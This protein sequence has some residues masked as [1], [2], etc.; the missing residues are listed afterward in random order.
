VEQVDEKPLH[1][2]VAEALG[3]TGCQPYAEGV[4]W[5]GRGTEPGDQTE[6][7]SDVPWYDTDWSA[8]GP[9]I[10]KYCIEVSN[11]G[12]YDFDEEERSQVDW[13]AVANAEIPGG[14]HEAEGPTPLKAVCNL[15]LAL[16]KS[17]KL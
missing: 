17:G 11:D 5:F 16:G 8:T 12:A 10:E 13:R 15:L 6:T 14:M 9:L 1:V 7:P 3:W 4:A 2:H